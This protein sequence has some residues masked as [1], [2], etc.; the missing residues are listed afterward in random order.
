LCIVP[1]ELQPYNIPLPD[2]LQSFTHATVPQ[3]VSAT[4]AIFRDVDKEREVPKILLLQ[5]RSWSQKMGGKWEMTGGAVNLYRPETVLRAAERELFEE[6]G[7]KLTSFDAYVGMYRFQA[8]WML[9]TGDN[10]KI[11]FIGSVKETTVDGQNVLDNINLSPMEHQVF[12]W[13]TKAQVEQMPLHQ[14]EDVLLDMDGCQA[15]PSSDQWAQMPYIS[16]DGKRLALKAFDRLDVVL[17]ER[18]K[19][20]IYH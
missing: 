17:A 7:V 16:E 9:W 18:R 15:M 8:P 5:T 11:M 6:A 1:D 12:C 3:R 4:V 19:G 20:K 13:A 10:L 14:A 2:F